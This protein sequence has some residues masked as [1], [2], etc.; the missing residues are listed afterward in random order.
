M[1]NDLARH[2]GR[3]PGIGVDLREADQRVARIG[4]DHVEG[5]RDLAVVGDGVLAAHRRD[6]QRRVLAQPQW[7]MSR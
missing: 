2:R 4:P 5:I 1:E 3:L 7:I 6:G